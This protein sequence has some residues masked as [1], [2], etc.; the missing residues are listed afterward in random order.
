MDINFIWDE[1]ARFN[2]ESFV[3]EDEFKSAEF[4]DPEY[5]KGILS[6][7]TY[8]MYCTYLVNEK[9]ETRIDEVRPIDLT[10]QSNVK[11]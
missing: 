2:G 9:E 11:T 7:V 5:M 8:V 4:A 10:F 1:E 6:P 3:C